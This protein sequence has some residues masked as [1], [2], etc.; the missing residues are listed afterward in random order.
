[1]QKLEANG[2]SGRGTSRRLVRLASVFALAAA[3]FGPLLLPLHQFGPDGH[4]GWTAQTDAVAAA[5]D[6]SPSAPC[7][8]AAEPTCSVCSL[9]HGNQRAAV[10]SIRC[11]LAIRV[12]ST[13]PVRASSDVA[14][15]RIPRATDP[16]RAP[17]FSA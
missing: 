1:M 7:P 16:A 4:F 3:L 13:L 12:T 17:P 6:A 5:I 8:D 10:A 2:T 14:P 11:G 9:L 15:A